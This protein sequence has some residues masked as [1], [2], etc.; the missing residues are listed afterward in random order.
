MAR[1]EQ[2]LRDHYLEDGPGFIQEPD[3]L[4][5]AQ[6]RTV[7]AIM[8]RIEAAIETLHGRTFITTAD[9]AWLD[10][11]GTERGILRFDGES[12]A[13]YRARI[14]LI[15]DQVT[16]PAILA[17]VDAILQVGTAELE[18][19]GSDGLWL[20]RGAIAEAFLGQRLY[21]GT[22]PWFSV[23]I[24]QQVESKSDTAFLIRSGASGTL[25]FLTRT[26]AAWDVSMFLD[27]QDPAPSDIYRRIYETIERLRAAGVSFRVE[28]E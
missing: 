3:E 10:Q 27:G 21:R 16:K 19:H 1:D 7:A 22:P 4:L 15:E 13:D 24:Q 11:H 25:S 2:A 20:S 26:S 17:A 12:D 14:Q 9:G 28:I 23:Y 6:I 18:E 8:A 5:D